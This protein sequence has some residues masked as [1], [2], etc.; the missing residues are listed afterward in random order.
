MDLLVVVLVWIV[1]DAGLIGRTPTEA[2]QFV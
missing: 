1:A 2:V